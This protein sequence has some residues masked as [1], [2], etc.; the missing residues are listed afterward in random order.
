MT[1]LKYIFLIFSLQVFIILPIIIK[2]EITIDNTAHNI[3]VGYLLCEKIKL[4][5][6]N[7]TNVRFKVLIEVLKF[8]L[9]GYYAV[10]TGTDTS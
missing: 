6:G 3:V 5:T 9:Q 8:S 4:Q 1:L 2:S 7:I 10:S